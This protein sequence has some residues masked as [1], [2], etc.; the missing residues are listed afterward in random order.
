MM[1]PAGCARGAAVVLLLCLSQTHA[2]DPPDALDGPPFVSCQAWAVVDGRTGDLLWGHEPDA[3]RKAA[4]TTKMMCAYVILELARHEPGVLEEMV[5]FSQLADDTPGSTAD[6]RAGESLPV[7]QCLYGLLL[8]SGND[9]GNALAEHFNGRFDPPEYPADRTNPA[10]VESHPT[11]ANFIAEMNRIAA[12][13]GMSGTF[14]R[15]PYGDGGRPDDATTTPRDLLMLARHALQ[16]PVFG[17]YV[18]TREY[19]TTVKTPSGETRPV[20]WKN[21]N[22]L[23]GITGY[24]GIKTGTTDLAGACLVS[25]GRRG[26]DHLLVCVLGSTT[27]EG[28]YIDTRNLFRWAW[29]QRG[30]RDEKAGQ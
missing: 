22:Q 14:Y 21:T 17:K 11:R 9:A 2:V 8:P 13:L 12:K 5:T 6:V 27:P 23:L 16:N 10:T 18:S 19:E 3:A 20:A 4:S 1:Y 15:L 30:H 26:D 25:S 7:R 28:R 24:D 29:V